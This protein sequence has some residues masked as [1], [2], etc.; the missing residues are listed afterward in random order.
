MEESLR[1]HRGLKA[2]GFN[3]PDGPFIPDPRNIPAEYI[4]GRLR[5][6]M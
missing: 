4:D 5:R 3:F 1:A 2:Q 6:L